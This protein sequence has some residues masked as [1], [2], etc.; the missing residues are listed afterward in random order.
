MTNKRPSKKS[1]WRSL[2]LV[3]AIG[4]F[5]VL[6]SSPALAVDESWNLEVQVSDTSCI[7]PITVPTWSPDANVYYIQ[8]NDVDLNMYSPNPPG[9]VNFSVG[10]GLQ[11]GTDNCTM[12]PINPSGDVVASVTSLDPELTMDALD[13]E[14]TA[15]SAETLYQNTN[16]IYG[17]ID[18]TGVST[19]GLKS[20]I[21]TVVWTPES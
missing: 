15:C 9:L 5:A 3:S 2:A 10:L 20:G 11:S 8:G 12:M 6:S 7:D 14:T 13:C 4:S 17:A 19:T 18:A 21:L 16:T 1:P